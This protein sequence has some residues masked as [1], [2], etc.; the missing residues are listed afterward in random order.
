[1]NKISRREFLKYCGLAAGALGLGMG[2]LKR[3]EA[4]LSASGPSIVW[5]HGSGCQGDSISLLNRFA[6]NGPGTS[7]DDVLI[8]YINLTY[9]AVV[10]TQAGEPAAVAAMKTRREGSYVLVVEGGI[11]TRFNGGCC[12]VWTYNGQDV[13]YKDAVLDF[14]RGTS[15]ILAVGTCAS[16]GGIPKAPPNP[17]GIMG[18]EELLVHEGVKEKTVINITGCPA[19]PD[20]IVGTIVKLILGEPL[21]LDAFNRPQFLYGNNVHDNCPRR[22]GEPTHVGFAEKF[23]E[24]YKCLM[25][26]GCRGPDTFSDCPSRKWNNQRNWCVDSNGMCI[27]CVEPEFPGGSIYEVGTLRPY[28]LSSLLRKLRAYAIKH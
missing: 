12:S 17:T 3:L 9:H 19:H 5:L 10:M 24:D 15:T 26:I 18:M 27:G 8:N 28:A 11:P 13:T 4:A 2:D 23:G 16:F 7:I 25:N 1:M 14:A 6:Q 21:P 20:W 22:E